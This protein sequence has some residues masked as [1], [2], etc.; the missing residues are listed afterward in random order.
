MLHVDSDEN[1]KKILYYLVVFFSAKKEK[2]LRVVK[3]E[4]AQSSTTVFT[5]P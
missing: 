2:E 1:N 4:I 5:C 3:I